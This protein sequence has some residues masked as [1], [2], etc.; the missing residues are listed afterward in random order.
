MGRQRWKVSTLTAA[1][2]VA[3]LVACD[4]EPTGF[5]GRY[6]V[7]R[8]FAGGYAVLPGPS[9]AAALGGSEKGGIQLAQASS[10]PT[11]VFAVL[12]SGAYGVAPEAPGATLTLGSSIITGTSRR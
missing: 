3:S 2:L 12:R 1:A 7:R 6:S 9:G 11:Q 8:F 5:T 10:D 4:G